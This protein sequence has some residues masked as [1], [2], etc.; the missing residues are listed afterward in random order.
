MIL[1]IGE[2]KPAYFTP[3]VGYCYRWE[4]NIILYRDVIQ[5][6]SV[7]DVKMF[8]YKKKSNIHCS[9]T[10]AYITRSDQNLK[11]TNILC[12]RCRPMF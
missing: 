12:T 6:I 2:K 9:K 8:T 7:S 3:W 5:F 4:D 11:G 1:K 10:N